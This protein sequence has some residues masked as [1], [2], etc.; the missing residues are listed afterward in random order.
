MNKPVYD[1]QS[2]DALLLHAY[3]VAKHLGPSR[4]LGHNAAA[5]VQQKLPGETSA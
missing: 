1:H 5:Y 3:Y 2:L 4:T